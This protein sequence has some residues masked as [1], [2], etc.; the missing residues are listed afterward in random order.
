MILKVFITARKRKDRFSPV[1]NLSIL[2]NFL[3]FAFFGNN[4]VLA[5]LR[6]SNHF[7]DFYSKHK[8]PTTPIYI[9]LI[10]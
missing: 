5:S 4:S 6:L 10:M 8:N 2:G 3:Y 9:K 7:L 1:C